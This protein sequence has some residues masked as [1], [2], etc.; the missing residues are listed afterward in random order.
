MSNELRR[1]QKPIILNSDLIKKIS[2]DLYR[3]RITIELKRLGVRD[4]LI[5]RENFEMMSD[6]FSVSVLHRDKVSEV[7]DGTYDQL[8]DPYYDLPPDVIEGIM[9]FIHSVIEEI[10]SVLRHFKW[11][12]DKR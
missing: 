8:L 7:I 1:S 3:I 6:H 10:D 9:N 4:I 2:D 12:L 5:D 11:T